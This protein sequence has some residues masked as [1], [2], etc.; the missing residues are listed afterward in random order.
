VSRLHHSDPHPVY[1]TQ[2]SHSVSNAIERTRWRDASYEHSVEHFGDLQWAN[3][4]MN[5]LT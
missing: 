1:A 4:Q 5:L 3:V 2:E